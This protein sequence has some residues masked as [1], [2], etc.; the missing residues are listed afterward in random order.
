M[1]GMPSWK[2][3]QTYEKVKIRVG[4]SLSERQ[5]FIY[6]ARNAQNFPPAACNTSK[7]IISVYFQASIEKIAAR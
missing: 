4:I 2:K 6:V 5:N 7:Y 3:V 1:I